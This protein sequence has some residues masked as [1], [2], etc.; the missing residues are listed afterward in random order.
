[1]VA[2]VRGGPDS[3][4][5]PRGRT[6]P[7]KSL[8]L[9]NRSASIAFQRPYMI[10]CMAP[11]NPSRHT[12]FLVPNPNCPPREFSIVQREIEDTVV[13]LCDCREPKQRLHLLRKMRILIDEAHR[14]VADSGQVSPALQVLPRNL[15]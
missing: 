14:A 9:A 8:R 2:Q 1:M 3:L 13:R 5:A 11:D 4:R 10:R 15:G 12:L 6:F 7:Y